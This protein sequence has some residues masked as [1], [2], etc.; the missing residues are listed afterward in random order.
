MWLLRC[1]STFG[2]AA[3]LC[4]CGGGG[5]TVSAV[6]G[7]A[8]GVSWLATL[9]A[10]PTALRLTMANTLPQYMY[11]DAGATNGVY[12]SPTA[13]A[14]EVQGANPGFP[15]GPCSQLAQMSAAVMEFTDTN[16]IQAPAYVVMFIPRTV[17]SCTQALQLGAAGTQ[18]FSVTVDP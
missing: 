12:P 13:F 6:P 15:A 11:I 1:V 3:A 7:G 8:P 4:G 14:S 2:L 17:G 16:G 18:T 10:N 9:R 5:G